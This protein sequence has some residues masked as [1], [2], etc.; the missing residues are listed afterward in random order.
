MANKQYLIELAIKDDKLKSSLKKSLESPEIQKSLGILGE[1]ITEYL[2][3]DIKQATSILGKVDWASLL[4]KDDFEH[5]Q[6]VVA[7]TVS[8]N[9]DLIKS[10]IKA[11]DTKGLKDT[12]EFVSELGNALKE[13][14]PGETVAGL[15][16]SMG[17]FIKTLKPLT[18]MINQMS[19]GSQN[20]ADSFNK[21]INN[22]DTSSINKKIKETSELASGML[23]ALGS[24]DMKARLLRELRSIRG[25]TAKLTDA[26]F[27]EKQMDA[28]LAKFT[29]AQAIAEEIASIMAQLKVGGSQKFLS[30]PITSIELLDRLEKLQGKLKPMLPTLDSSAITKEVKAVSADVDA[31]LKKIED[32]LE[33]SF[34]RIISEK[35]GSIKVTVDVPTEDKLI[36]DLNKVIEKVNAKGT[37]SL[38][39]VGAES[40]IN[41]AQ[42][43]ILANTIE[44][45]DRM[46]EALKF[47][48][49]EDI[50]L[51]LGVKMKDIGSNVGDQLRASINEYFDNPSNKVEVP[52]KLVISDE[53][54]AVLGGSGVTIVGNGA[55]G[56]ITAEDLAK[57]L[58]TPIEVK[59]QEEKSNNKPSAKSI[60]LDYESDYAKEV[61]TVFDDLFD[62]IERGGENAK[63]IAQFFEFKGLNLSELKDSKS[64]L[65]ILNAF[66]DFLARGEASILDQVSSLAKGGTR[67]RATLGF[68][69][70]IKDAVFRYNLPNISTP[71]DMKRRDA[72]ELVEEYYIPQNKVYTSLS[73]L[74]RTDDKNYKIPTVEELDALITDLPNT[75][76]GLGESFLPALEALKNL[77]STITDPNNKESIRRFKEATDKF[78]LETE[79]SYRTMQGEMGFY[80]IGVFYKGHNKHKKQYDTLYRGGAY[81]GN[82]IAN[83]LDNI[84]YFEIYDDPSGHGS[85]GNRQ[86][87]MDRLSRL[88][89][90][91]LRRKAAEASYRTK[92]PDKTSVLSE[93][94]E[95]KKFKPKVRVDAA[96]KEISEY[97]EAAQKRTKTIE[98]ARKKSE[99]EAKAAEELRKQELETAKKRRTALKSQRTK[100]TNKLNNIPSE[101]Q[102]LL[103][104]EKE[105]FDKLHESNL[106]HDLYSQYLDEA[107]NAER[108]GDTDKFKELDQKAKQEYLRSNKLL[109]EYSNLSEYITKQRNSLSL[110]ATNLAKQ[111]EQLS[112][113]IA[114]L[115]GKI[116]KNSV[117]PT[118]VPPVKQQLDALPKAEYIQSM[119]DDVNAIDTKIDKAQKKA[120]ELDERVS[121]KFKAEKYN[122]T[123]KKSEK[124]TRDK[125]QAESDRLSSLTSALDEKDRVRLA[126]TKG[127]TNKDKNVISQLFSDRKIHQLINSDQGLGLTKNSQLEPI[128]QSRLQIYQEG[129]NAI[130]EFL[131]KHQDQTIKYVKDDSDLLELMKDVDTRKVL[132][133]TFNGSKE[134]ENAIREKINAFKVRM[135]EV[136]KSYIADYIDMWSDKNL[137]ELMDKDEINTRTS[138][139]AKGS[140]IVMEFYRRIL[141]GGVPNRDKAYQYLREESEKYQ[142]AI[143]GDE[144]SLEKIVMSVWEQS[145]Q[146]N[147]KTQTADNRVKDAYKTY[148]NQWL[149]T[150]QENMYE[151]LFG[152]LNEQDIAIK[153]RKNDELRGL[154]SSFASQYL[155]QFGESLLT[156]DQSNLLRRTE[157]GY[158]KFLNED[159]TSLVSKQ[160]TDQANV[161]S[162]IKEKAELLK[163]HRFDLLKKISDRAGKGEDTASLESALTEVENEL[164]QYSDQ[165]PHLIREEFEADLLNAKNA[166]EAD[167]RAF[168]TKVSDR[169]RKEEM[170]RKATNDEQLKTVFDASTAKTFKSILPS[171]ADLDTLRLYNDETEK[172]IELGRQRLALAERGADTETIDRDITTQRRATQGYLKSYIEGRKQVAAEHDPKLQATRFIEQTDRDL[173]ILEQQT[174]AAEDKFKTAGFHLEQM[175]GDDYKNSRFYKKRIESLKSQDVAEYVRSGNYKAAR[176]KGLKQADEEFEA[177]LTEK[178]G[179]DVA[180][181]L[182]YEFSKNKDRANVNEVL[183]GAGNTSRLVKN[184]F[185]DAMAEARQ[186][187]T[188]SAAYK[189]LL[190]DS[191][192]ARENIIKDKLA[193]EKVKTDA[194]V[195]EI[196]NETKADITK[197][198]KADMA[199]SEELRNAVFEEAQKA[200]MGDSSEYRRSIVPEV[201][202]RLIQERIEAGR[203]E[204]KTVN[205]HYYEQARNM[206]SELSPEMY[207]MINEQ[208]EK[209]AYDAV[210]AKIKGLVGDNADIL[211]GLEE[212]RDK[213]VKKHTGGIVE[214]Y[215]ENL[216]FEETNTYKGVNIREMVKK[217]LAN[218]VAYYEQRYIESSGKLG[219]L[220]NER[221]RAKS[222]GELGY[223]EVL[224]PEVTRIRAEAEARLSAEKEKQVALTEKLTTLTAQNAEPQMI[225]A[226]ASEL[227]ATE[228]EIG[229]LQALA[230]GAADALSLRKNVREEELA[231]NTFTPDKARLWLIDHIAEAKRVLETGTDDEK[232]KA[233]AQI[234]K[235]EPKLANIEKIIEDSK[236]EAEKPRTILDMVT[237]AIRDGLAGATTGGVVNLDASLYNIATESTLQEILRLLGGNGAVEY[238]NQLKAELNKYRPKYERNAEGGTQGGGQSGKQGRANKDLDKLNADGQRIF[239]ELEAE[240]KVF[241]TSLKKGAK[242]YTKDFDFAKAI[243][244]QVAVVKKQTKGS[245][246]YVKEQTKLT[247]LYQDYYNKT[248]GKGKKK[249]GQPGQSKWAEQ[250]DLGKI[251]G[252]K[253]LLLF[254]SQRADALVGLN[255]GIGGQDEVKTDK[256]TKKNN[257]KKKTQENVSNNTES[258]IDETKVAEEISKAIGKV[259]DSGLELGEKEAAELAEMVRIAVSEALKNDGLGR[260]VNDSVKTEIKE[261]VKEGISEAPDKVTKPDGKLPYSISDDSLI[262]KLRGT[263]GGDT[264]LLAQQQTLALVLAELKNISNKIP[265]IGKSGVKSSAQSLLEEFQKMA[266]GSA[267]DSK[268]RVSFFD[269]VNGAMSPSL[270]GAAH[271]VSQK[272]LDTLSEQ[273]GADKGYRSQV[274]TH[275]DSD[276]TWFSAKDLDH[277]KNNLGEFGANSIKQQVL[278]TKDSITV[279]DM[280]MVETA[281]KAAQAIDILKKAGSNVD[282]AVLESLTDLGA[283]YQS[284]NL[285]AISAKG[286]MDLLGVKN[287]KNDGKKQTSAINPEVARKGLEAY[288]KSDADNRRSQYIFNSFDGETLK[289]QLVDVEGNISKVILAWDDLEKKVRVVSDTSTSSVDATVNKIKQ[290]RVEI[291]NAKKELLLSDGDDAGFLAAEKNVNDIVKQIESGNLRGDDLSKAIS[292]LEVARTNLAQEG[293]KIHKLILQNN[294]LRGGTTEV[295]Q[296]I[297]QGTRIRGIM[298]DAIETDDQNG[299]QL[300]KVDSNAPKYLQEYVAEYNNLLQVQQQ[301]I[302][303]GQINNP[304][305][306][307][308][309]KVQTASV[310]R[311]GIAAMTAYNNT[312]KLQERSE[313]SE[314]KTYKARNGVEHALGGSTSINPSEVNR[315]NLL[316]YA[317]E[318]L[319]ADLASVK[320][321]ATTGKLTGVL[322]EN[323]YVVADMAVE[324]DKATGKLH[325][326]QEKERESLS[327]LPGFMQGLKA[328][329][330]AIVQYVASMT[331]IYRVLGEIRKGIQYI[332]EIDKA[333]TELKKVTDK[334][335]E[336]YQKFLKTASRTA[337]ELGST[338]SQITEATATFAKLGYTMEMAAEMAEAAI[339]YKN[340]GDGIASAEDA[341][342]SIISTLKGFGLEASETMRIVDRFNEVGNKFAIT[343]KGI[344][345]A[346]QL[347]ASA[348]NEGANSLDESI[349]LITAANEVVNDPSS[350]GTALKTLTLRLRGSKTELEEMG[351]DVAD[352]ATT[353]ST[354]QA[355]L[356]ALTG[357]R[358]DIMADAQ[359]FKS[360]TQILREMAGAWEYMTDVQ[361]ASA[362][363]LMGGKRQANTLSALIQNFD[364]A[365]RVIKASESSAG[366]A[367]RENEVF[368]DSFEGRLQQLSNTVQT[369]WHEALDTETIKDAIQLLTKL[370]DTLDFE[371]SGLVDIVHALVKGLSMLVDIMPGSNFGY[372]LIAFLGAKTISKHGLLD[373][374]ENLKNKGEDSIDTLT[375]KLKTLDTEITDLANKADKQSGRAQKNTL[376]KLEA[377]KELRT[378]VQGRLDKLQAN[379]QAEIDAMSLSKDEQQEIVESFDVESAKKKLSARKSTI[380]RRTNELQKQGMTPEQI[381]A[382]PKIQQWNK[383]L[384]E[385]KKKLDEYNAK[386][387][388]TDA[389]LENTNATTTQ[390]SATTSNNTVAQNANTGAQETNKASKQQNSVATDTLT[391]DTHENTTATETNT[392]AQNANTSAVGKNTGKLK[393]W[394]KQIV[395]TMAYMALIQGV[396]TLLDSVTGLIKDAVEAAKPKTFEDLRE[397]FE[398]LSSELAESQSELSNLTSTLED[399]E[400]QIREIQSLGSLSFTKQEELENLQKQS[401]ELNR[402]IEMQKI[403]TQNK[404]KATNSAALSAA[405][406]YMQQSAE[407]DKTLE[408]AAEKS[409]ETG[410]KI[411]GIVDGLLMVGGAITMIATGWTGAG[412]IVGGAIMAAGMAGA[413]SAVGG[414][415]GKNAGESKYSKQQTNQEAIDAYTTKRA[416]YLKRI[417]DAYRQGNAEEYDKIREEYNKF[418]SM[419]AENIGGLMEYVS[420]IDY[421][422]LSSET[423]RAQYESYNRIINQY[424]LANGGSVT[425]AI[426]SILDYDRYERTGYEFDKIQAEFKKGNITEEE[427]RSQMEALIGDNLKAE[428][429]ALNISVN[430]VL[431]SYLQLGKAAKSDTSLTDS[432]GKISAVTS[433]FDDLGN[434]MDEIGENGSVSVGTLES[435]KEKFGNLDEFEALYQVLA[436]GQGDLE[437][438]VKSV[439]NAY[440]GQIQL[441]SNL[442]DEEMDIMVSRLESLGVLNAKEVLATREKGQENL[443]ALKLSYAIDLSNY[444]TAEQAKIAIA[445]MAGL[446][447]A[448]IADNEIAY[449]AALYNVDLKN[450]ATKE[451]QKIAIARA[452][453][454]AEAEA[455]KAEAKRAYD[456]KEIDEGEYLARIAAIDSSLDFDSQY[457]TIQEILNN[458]YADF[459]FDFD[460]QVGIGSNYDKVDAAT[461][462]AFD[463]WMSYYDRV[464]AISQSKYD[465]IQNEIDMAEKKGQIVGKNYY[466]TQKAIAEEQLALLGQQKTEL[467]KYVGYVDEN[468][469]W[470]AGIY[471]VGSDEWYDA[472]NQLA[473]LE[474][475]L[476]DVNM[477]LQ[478]ISDATAQVDWAL[479]DEAHERFG[480]L[481]DDLSSMR[482]L[483]APNGEDDW[484]DDD[485][486]WTDKGAAYLAT[487]VNDL[488][489]YENQLENV[490][491][492]LKNYELDYAGNEAY[493]KNLGIDSEQELYD[494][495][496]KLTEQQF[497][498]QKAINDTTK[499]VKDMYDS[500]I[501]AIEEWANEAVDAYNDYIS[502]VKEAL[503]AER[504]LHDFKN[505][506]KDDK[507]NI[508]QLERRISALSG[509]TDAGDIAELK[510]LQAELNDAKEELNE[511]YYDHAK[512]AQSKALDDEADAYADTMDRFIEQQRKALDTAYGNVNTF[513][514]A[515]IGAVSLNAPAIVSAYQGLGVEVDA[516]IIDPWYQIEAAMGDAER[517]GLSIMNS[518]VGEGGVF[519][520]F[521]DSATELLGTPWS[522]MTGEN[523]PVS[524]F[525][526]NIDSAMSNVKTS[527]E[528]NLLNPETGALSQLYNKLQAVLD[529]AKEAGVKLEEVV[530][531]KQNI[532]TSCPVCGNSPCTCAADALSTAR[533]KAIAA[534]QAYINEHNM[535]ESNRG[536]WGS[537]A[538]F[539]ALF[540]NYEKLG[541]KS[542]DIISQLVGKE[543]S[544]RTFTKVTADNSTPNGWVNTGL[545]MVG[546]NYDSSLVVKGSDGANYYPYKSN[547]KNGYVK[548]GEGYDIKKNGKIDYHSWK[549][550]YLSKGTLGTKKDQWA[551]TDEPWFGD[552]LVLIP[553]KDGNLSYM[554]KGTS[555][556]PAAITENLVEWGKLNPNMMNM[557]NATPNINM[558]SNAI[559]Q[560]QY[561][562]SFDSL[563]H[564]DHCDQN[565]L[566]DLEKMVDNKIDKFSRDLNYGLKKYSR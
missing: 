208:V 556:I 67:N 557:P 64:P 250:G 155:R 544:G 233:A 383:E 415:I 516:A 159:K 308:A 434:A 51:D 273:Y 257:K 209:F 23:G 476:D 473:N 164:V 215:K 549:P 385:G 336:T 194:R 34:N 148:V 335:D 469:N 223:D 36:D 132:A 114:E 447:I 456:N 60:S 430:Q 167:W 428:F 423:E 365:E 520:E 122:V 566:K 295:K 85:G 501:D 244:E 542:S 397:E 198:K 216:K 455:D 371:D 107:A 288:A 323:N 227:Q 353:T 102:A 491:T 521:S 62:A 503:D 211:K 133:G 306:Q 81:S 508:S 261:G 404:Q 533:T 293:E 432:I 269:L 184:A 65:G 356:L 400:S 254:K 378:D 212:E 99:Q 299:L 343:S 119:I 134:A 408:E 346:L 248:F 481:H 79:S 290:Y 525:E 480:N 459:S 53:D 44:W 359:T 426:D 84:E 252:L 532:D 123:Y 494:T 440:V 318:V 72:R 277:F 337:Q 497:D 46:K 427:A 226:I 314:M 161:D 471:E 396:M 264:R 439:A 274:H 130:D 187:Y 179:E 229:R 304:K 554:R 20:F 354:L 49:K 358:V 56:G 534:G 73:Q 242:T 26:M 95:V 369:K 31:T 509:S 149:Y 506:I 452:R 219:V 247:L 495:R 282:D 546:Y 349:A 418:E 422:T 307:D 174:K 45:R 310:K 351:E 322:R 17:S 344:G 472:V 320:F 395:K 496:E 488:K 482:D 28:Y 90:Y 200:G 535:L 115:D 425:D 376:Q 2:E 511:K 442:T 171:D 188:D 197:L 338:I 129:L 412:A 165:L 21:F 127:L 413:G 531:K 391:Q 218:E 124:N 207:Q 540:S 379:K 287:Y 108:N 420:S 451:E 154:I 331:S 152:E 505:S 560:P 368:L 448:D 464:I 231:N 136:G 105:A 515:V 417:D 507:K 178:L 500:Q 286:L 14:S 230:D 39:L 43:K 321:N 239:G 41:E 332:R 245:L 389:T 48:K 514:N 559:H 50:E 169:Q 485:G 118:K 388:E 490:S 196:W 96:E 393:A 537:D 151:I 157:Y 562:F 357:G 301:Y 74:R 362:L 190:A 350:V 504:D 407:T 5:L 352:M 377:K 203:K 302:K 251:E 116:T 86:D 267:M 88:E 547:P 42:N 478:D 10:F 259:A 37:N 125:Y 47:S 543:A 214:N 160:T 59:V 465:Q 8:A 255:Y 541:G 32:G 186:N 145:E 58:T 524:A 276:Q 463:K 104:L 19:D 305:I 386:V 173:Y 195:Q 241:T 61:L 109:D 339:V 68:R 3:K 296:A 55:G 12:I 262:G 405:G 183:D 24:K 266:A 78:A 328:K 66:E 360:T 380:T 402:Q 410:Q 347:S 29:T 498:Y 403:L 539:M 327:G 324:Y 93:D 538:N 181:Q 11:E 433:A 268:E 170:S 260:D 156:D 4:G 120:G 271:S 487:Y 18:D 278:L 147:A 457:A 443:D 454:R 313:A 545:S 54:K 150:I 30:S 382:D 210:M 175:Q 553:G 52:V 163:Q 528:T 111:N 224:N 461:K 550:L 398:T 206:R 240:A 333:L 462:K 411:G 222:V 561:D 355:K 89:K 297:T 110:Q 71:E 421:N 438:S 334:T 193:D 38:K 289:Y 303:D 468:G 406:A 153:H 416:D 185:A 319:G 112:Q 513:M 162:I 387:K 172:L 228:K 284:K 548:E 445:Q 409:K 373:F 75:W 138:T 144:S 522:S 558:I 512:D 466:N 69:D 87:A 510:K 390:A 126:S 317:K 137:R 263:V 217:E 92:M 364:T 279:F 35:L 367:L 294:K 80:K 146:T 221:E 424:S 340:V 300:F 235:W 13:I 366:S 1:G 275:A 176:D 63:K 101:E 9:K 502:V 238:A 40:A 372:T 33:K 474:G 479:F 555:V 225:N 312:V 493:Y 91:Q 489:M 243:Q 285:G 477:T 311:L 374:F 234:A 82:K 475:Q 392:S 15:T 76:N 527:I 201:R 220:K 429:D 394:G 458:A 140:S 6:Q 486:M 182:V 536:Q 16:R 249:K 97:K 381:Q 199:N 384:E 270:S 370:V 232:A 202:E 431:D 94:V 345:E 375:E 22:F 325:L 484:F 529:K 205:Q 177:K 552:E 435:L 341:A 139:D 168:R 309:L 419:M 565:T 460:G 401:A 117:E 446:K 135:T 70:I 192:V 113:E 551:I 7:K 363:E 158:N 298:G 272:L 518:W 492:K 292:Q 530:D 283:R 526:A 213:L 180:K 444:G 281:E 191:K 98:D 121:K 83:S 414:A 564:V 563:V 399:V 25:E 329:S 204:Q 258:S 437:G 57:A 523:S 128:V 517:D 236:P 316:K 237:S 141:E 291:E 103:N 519:Y 265:T 467:E 470:I 253:D 246:E 436:T 106:A 280:T 256:P 342:D 499:S 27:D 77:R 166:P 348:L 449:W 189:K 453:A 483:I 361:R 330:R 326:Y 142:K 450:Y 315:E 100:N 131:L 143:Q 441:L